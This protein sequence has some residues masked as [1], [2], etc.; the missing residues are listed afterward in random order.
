MYHGETIS[1]RDKEARCE[2]IGLDDR[3]PVAEPPGRRCP[4]AA[5]D[6]RAGRGLLG[7]V[8]ESLVLKCGVGVLGWRLL[9]LT[10]YS[11]LFTPCSLRLACQPTGVGSK[12]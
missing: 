12:E 1:R 6:R 4:G 8:A 10:P 9:L 3:L 7:G 5:A 2:A 11:L